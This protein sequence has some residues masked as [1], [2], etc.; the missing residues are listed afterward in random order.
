MQVIVFDYRIY[1]ILYFFSSCVIMKYKNSSVFN[2]HYLGT[3]MKS[4]EGRCLQ[5]ITLNVI[6]S[7]TT[8]VKVIS[9]GGGGFNMANN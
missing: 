6:V 7:N 1:I 4:S 8:T 9:E 3:V 2:A 5:I